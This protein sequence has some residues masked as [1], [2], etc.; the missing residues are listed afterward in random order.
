MEELVSVVKD[1][2]PDK[3]TPTIITQ[4]SDYLYVEYQSPTFGF[5]DDVEFWFPKDRSAFRT[6][7]AHCCCQLRFV[8][9]F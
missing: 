7:S 9:T 2:T 8:A 5:I 1:L 3:F 6:A 4:T